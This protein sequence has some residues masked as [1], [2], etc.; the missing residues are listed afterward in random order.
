MNESIVSIDYQSP[1]ETS[2]IEANR[3]LIMRKQRRRTL[4]IH[5]GSNVLCKSNGPI[6]LRRSERLRKA[7]TRYG[8][9]PQKEQTMNGLLYGSSSSG[10]SGFIL[11]GHSSDSQT[12]M[13]SQDCTGRRI[14]VLNGSQSPPSSDSLCPNKDI[15][16]SLPTA[17]I[18]AVK[19]QDD[20][21][22]TCNKQDSLLRSEDSNDS[23]NDQSEN[24]NGRVLLH[25]S[26]DFMVMNT[27]ISHT[28]L[29]QRMIQMFGQLA[30]D[31]VSTIDYSYMYPY[32]TIDSK[33]FFLLI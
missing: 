25:H 22:K 9:P 20:R 3:S 31:K 6:T 10:S 1:F 7:S 8:S 27:P 24:D 14:T 28:H 2:D 30:W 33:R 23:T 4:A 21:D 11:G 26:S 15:I 19:I 13:N 29:Q 5:N 12:S 17:L 32:K 16:G 18:H